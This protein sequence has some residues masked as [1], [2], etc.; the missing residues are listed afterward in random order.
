MG[1]PT[2]PEDFIKHLKEQ[3]NEVQDTFVRYY[4]NTHKWQSIKGLDI[5]KHLEDIINH[6]SAR[7]RSNPKPTTTSSNTQRFLS[8]AATFAKAATDIAER[9]LSP[10]IPDPDNQPTRQPEITLTQPTPEKPTKPYRTPF[11]TFEEYQTENLKNQRK[12]EKGKAPLHRPMPTTTTT[13]RNIR[14]EETPQPPGSYPKSLETIQGN[15]QTKKRK[16]SEEKITTNLDDRTSGEP[17]DHH[18]P[19]NPTI[20]TGEPDDD[21][22]EPS[23]NSDDEPNDKDDSIPRW[24]RD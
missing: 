23:D 8:T 15:R 11:Q 24:I 7:Y 17:Y 4:R 19:P 9:A 18:P 21:P 20:A 12:Q 13:T 14:I 22:S 3:S 2:P 6:I 10:F 5:K 16:K 1:A